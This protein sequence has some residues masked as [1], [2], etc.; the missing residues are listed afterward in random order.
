MASYRCYFLDAA[1]HIADFN[2]IECE[3]DAQAQVRADRK[4]AASR[5]PG[6]ELWACKR[7]VYRAREVA[8][9]AQAAPN[10][11]QISP[12]IPRERSP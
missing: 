10:A 9:P 5:Y 6:I 11:H 12:G 8:D 4:L 2:L 7:R 1:D 3:T